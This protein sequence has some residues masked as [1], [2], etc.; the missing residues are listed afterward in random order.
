[1]RHALPL[2]ALGLCLSGCTPPEHDQPDRFEQLFSGRLTVLD[3]T[4]PLN[5][6]SPYWPGPAGNPFTYD[7]LAAHESGAPILGAYRTPEHY[8]THLDAPIHSADGQPSVDRLTA[9]DLF[10][11]AAVIDVSASCAADPDYRLSKEDLLAWETQYGPLPDGAIVLMYTGWSKKWSDYAAYA[12]Q[13]AE[14]RL[15]FPGFSEEAAR[16]LIDERRIKGIGI[17]NM[18]IDYGLSRD[19]SVHT[20]VNGAGKYHLENVADLHHLP[21]TG[22][23]LI[24]APIKIEG[25]SGGQVRLF[26]VLPDTP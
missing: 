16:F 18:S 23:F 14:G 8:G 4:H 5:S 17:D 24:V 7:I 19:F 3:L 25:G 13:D 10:G 6:T 11:P 1:M 2:L 20:I 12:N 15:H 26:A 9:A 21:P 22:A